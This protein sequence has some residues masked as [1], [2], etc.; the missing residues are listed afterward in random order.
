ME[1]IGAIAKKTARQYKDKIAV[2]DG[3]RTLTYEEL[4]RRAKQLANG[5]KDKGLRKGDRV[6]ILMSNRLECIELDLA[7]AYAGIIKVP[8]N[9]RLHPM[10]HQFILQQSG[11]ILLIGEE[12]LIEP[13]DVE[14]PSIFVGEQYEQ[15]VNTNMAE[16]IQEVVTE[17]DLYAIM[18]TSGT[19]GRPKGVMLS[20]RNFIAGA[21]SLILSC[22]MK[23]EDV[24]GHVAPLTH[25]SNFLAQCSYILG[26]KQV[27]YN[28]FDPAEFIHDLFQDQINVIFLVPTM[29][30]LMIHDPSF[31]PSLLKSLKS[32]NMAGAPIAEEK[33]KKAMSLLGP[34]FV[35]TYG[36]VEAPMTITCMPRHEL[37]NRPLSCGAAGPFVEMKIVDHIGNELKPREVGEVICRGSLVMKGY[38]N[39]EEATKDTLKDGWLYTG[40]LGWVDEDG[41]LH[42]VDRKKDV[43]IT[44]GANVYPREVE[45]ILSLHPAVKET[46]V[47]GIPDE[48]WGEAVY[49]HVVLREKETTTEQELIELCKKHLASFKKPIGI[50]FVEQ[51]PKSSYGKILK[52][53]IRKEYWG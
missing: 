38:W 18:Y 49:A 13:I 46:C 31:D 19:T 52:K 12:A 7:C 26:C 17:D 6:A 27:V 9:Y 14:I 53:E 4:H 15:W 16:E 45:E 48:K 22:E 40:D 34:I 1:T 47:F 33:L 32:I 10:E 42:L 30:N 51:L 3:N 36:Q 50:K 28:K 24:I 2:V 35:E 37:E 20:H 44:G 5:M 23:S 11:A 25:G 29:V 43:I 41:Y 21:L 8:L 39:N